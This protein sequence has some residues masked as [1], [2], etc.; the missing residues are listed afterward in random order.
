MKCTVLLIYKR[1]WNDFDAHLDMNFEDCFSFIFSF[2]VW[3][4]ANCV[5]TLINLHEQFGENKHT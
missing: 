5:W 2:S 1:S 4:G 3:K